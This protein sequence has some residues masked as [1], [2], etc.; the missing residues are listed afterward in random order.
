M[1]SIREWRANSSL[2]RLDCDLLLKHLLNCSRSVI[3]ASPEKLLVEADIAQL[4][5][6]KKRRIA[7]EPIAYILGK[8]EFWGLNFF[9]DDNVLVPRPE[10][11]L[12]VELAERCIRDGQSILEL[13]TGCGAVAIALVQELASKGK[14]VSLTATDVSPEALKICKRNLENHNI[15]IRLFES[16]WFSNISGSF[17]MIISNPPYIENGNP[18]LLALG[19]EP[20]VALVS[21]DDGLDAIREIIKYS[22]THIKNDGYLIL[23]HGCEQGTKVQRLFKRAG[24]SNVSTEKDLGGR[25]R[26]TLGKMDH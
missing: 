22:S 23:E 26:V 15:K 24:F 17:D 1:I 10:T 2:D 25:D 16:N 8:K 9:V 14:N 7:G 6:W 11:E 3:A 18:H 5:N 20:A 19:S 12:L 4:E 21:G 13:G